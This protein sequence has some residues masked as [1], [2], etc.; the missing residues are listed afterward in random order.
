MCVSVHVCVFYSC[1]SINLLYLCCV[2]FYSITLFIT[3]FTYPLERPLVSFVFLAISSEDVRTF[4][5]QSTNHYMITASEHSDTCI[6]VHSLLLSQYLHTGLL[7]Q[8]I[9]NWASENARVFQRAVTIHNFTIKRRK[10]QLFPLL[11]NTGFSPFSVS[12]LFW[13]VNDVITSL[14]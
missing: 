13:W 14:F 8:H 7:L 3:Q 5:A 2:V 10:Y 4:T 9:L 12:Y 11:S 1:C 6:L